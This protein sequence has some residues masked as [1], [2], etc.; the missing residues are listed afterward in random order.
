MARGEQ[1]VGYQGTVVPERK[2][3]EPHIAPNSPEE[4][5]QILA[6]SMQTTHQPE[7]EFE[8]VAV[9]NPE[10]REPAETAVDVSRRYTRFKVFCHVEEQWLDPE[11][12]TTTGAA[13][14]FPN[15]AKAKAVLMAHATEHIEVYTTQVRMRRG[16]AVYEEVDPS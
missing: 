3:R 5:E 9:G 1:S 6:R 10:D 14:I 15:E 4:R 7:S 2:N 8:T 11:G 13:G 16:P 12:D